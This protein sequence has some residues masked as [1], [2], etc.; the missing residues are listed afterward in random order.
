LVSQR[1]F[2]QALHVRTVSVGRVG[3][4]NLFGGSHRLLLHG[5][6]GVRNIPSDRVPASADLQSY[7]WGSSGTVRYLCLRLAQTNKGAKMEQ[8]GQQEVVTANVQSDL[9]W[10]IRGN[11]SHS[12]R[13][14]SRGGSEANRVPVLVDLLRQVPLQGVGLTGED[15]EVLR[16]FG[17]STRIEFRRRQTV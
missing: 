4:R 9:L 12:L 6:S 2:S 5:T 17:R 14:A 8:P 10:G 16:P 13:D 3:G 7:D 11:I 1:G 15:F